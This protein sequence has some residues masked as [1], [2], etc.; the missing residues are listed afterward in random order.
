MR[1][2]F[3]PTRR[4]AHASCSPR[5]PRLLVP[6]ALALP[7]P[8]AVRSSALTAV[9]RTHS[10]GALGVY[11]VTAARRSPPCATGPVPPVL[12]DRPPAGVDDRHVLRLRLH[13]EHPH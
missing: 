9:T 8:A 5:W 6:R 12:A 2:V 13:C 10:F 4:G 7:A 3:R 1:S 11:D